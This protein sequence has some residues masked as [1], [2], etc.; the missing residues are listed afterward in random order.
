M[1]TLV[2]AQPDA[3]RRVLPVKLRADL[4]CT[5]QAYQGRTYWVLKDPVSL[6]YFRFHEEEYALV[7]MLDGTVSLAD[8]RRRFEA[9]FAPQRLRLADI[10]RFVG[11]LHASGLL[12]SQSPGQGEVLLARAKNERRTKLRAALTNPL[13]IRFPGVDP[14]RLLTWLYRRFWWLFHPLVVTACFLLIATA[15]AL[16][17]LEFRVFLARMPAMNEFF[18]PRNVL[19]LAGALL[20]CKV[21]HELGHGLT[22][23]HFRGECH[24][25]GFLLIVFTPAM[26]CDVSDSWLLPSK[27][28]RMAIGAGGMYVELVVAAL[29][30]FGWWYSQPGLF[31]NICLSLMFIGSVSTLVV[32]ANPL[33]RFDGYYILSDFLEIPNLAARGSQALQRT[34]VRW[35]LGIELPQSTYDPHYRGAAFAL[36][37]VASN[38]YRW[39]VIC[40]I[41]LIAYRILQPYGLRVVGIALAALG[42]VMLVIVPAW[43]TVQMLRVPGR[44]QQARRGRVLTSLLVSIAALV[45]VLAV[46]LPYRVRCATQIE[47]RDAAAVYVPIAGRLEALHVAAGDEVVAGQPLAT[48]RNTD[49]ELE[50]AALEGR[51]ARVQAELDGLRQG[52]FVDEL[53]AR[54]IDAVVEMLAQ[55]ESQLER[56]RDDFRRLTIVAPADGTVIPPARRPAAS[57]DDTQLSTW[58]GSPLETENLGAWLD[59]ATLLC[60]LGDPNRLEALLVVDQADVDL[61][62]PGQR[63]M[64]KVE[65]LP[66]EVLDGTLSEVARTQ[67]E[68]AP[69]ALTIRGGGTLATRTDREGLERPLRPSYLARAEFESGDPRLRPAMRGV[70]KIEADRQTLAARLWRGLS[71]LFRFQL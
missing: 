58:S 66:H 14:E 4:K 68:V 43:R 34:L 63:A 22:C 21:L 42:T 52:R 36:Y 65:S 56:R 38:L 8:L 16:V 18:G 40:S 28:R 2:D 1:A 5:P 45:L 44:A 31:N 67:L 15:A 69:H 11:R 50:L 46:P 62:R 3:D 37:A 71:S 61:V 47:P 24:S 57:S 9:Q 51:R 25:I 33:M 29:A 12:L 17:T 6:R 60:Q 26:Y 49:V 54:Q 20:V 55:V 13:V 27:W 7:Q 19:W 32:N 10:E 70:A 53:A 64:I 30:T 48:L 35:C 41:L 59:E 23:K 39:L